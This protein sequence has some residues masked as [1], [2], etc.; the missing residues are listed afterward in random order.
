MYAPG[1]TVEGPKV[2]IALAKVDDVVAT[3]LPINIVVTAAGGD[4]VGSATV[5]DDV[6]TADLG[7]AWVGDDVAKIVVPDLDVGA[8]GVEVDWRE[9]PEKS[10]HDRCRVVGF[11]FVCGVQGE[12]QLAVFAVSGRAVGVGELR[13]ERQRVVAV[14]VVSRP[15]REGDLAFARGNG[16]PEAAV[17]GKVD[18]LAPVEHAEGV[19]AGAGQCQLDHLASVAGKEG[20]KECEASRVTFAQAG[21]RDRIGVES[22]AGEGVALVLRDDEG[23]AG[24]QDE[25]SGVLVLRRD[26]RGGSAAGERGSDLLGEGPEVFGESADD[27][28]LISEGG[29]F[30]EFKVA[31]VVGDVIGNRVSDCAGDRSYRFRQFA[32]RF[33]G[34]V[35]QPLIG[36]QDVA[37][38]DFVDGDHGLDQTLGAVLLDLPLKAGIGLDH[39]FQQDALPVVGRGGLTKQ[40]FLDDI[41]IHTQFAQDGE[42]D[43]TQ[44]AGREIDHFGTGC[45]LLQTS[46]GVDG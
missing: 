22:A 42:V 20:K 30:G 32:P 2:V 14:K 41:R 43:I 46:G 31:A 4:P 18:A 5:V 7:D 45:D 38:N 33:G 13:P 16:E 24:I 11:G 44:A 36:L 15:E 1:R 26:L 23:L 19:G 3:S 40:R 21:G 6:A 12:C 29:D 27:R 17:A 10:A 8:V 37:R 35:E 25:A 9:I 28:L 39:H 34:L